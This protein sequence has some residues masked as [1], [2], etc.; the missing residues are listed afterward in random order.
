MLQTI[1][2]WL[3]KNSPVILLGIFGGLVRQINQKDITTWMFV[4]GMITSIFVALL[5]FFLI[6]DSGIP[7]NLKIVIIGIAGY[8]AIQV[9]EI[10]NKAILKR[11]EKLAES[12]TQEKKK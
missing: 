7:I 3:E 1:F 11:I 4:C 12:E 9:L 6:A 5:V 8:S 2:D 10:I